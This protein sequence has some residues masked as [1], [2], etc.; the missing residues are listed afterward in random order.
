MDP[1]NG[2]RKQENVYGVYNTTCNILVLHKWASKTRRET[3]KLRNEKGIALATVLLFIIV[4]LLLGF[5]LTIMSTYDHQQAL[6]LE[7]QAKAYYIA[8]SGADALGSYI[9]N[10]PD[11]LTAQEMSDYVDAVV[12]AGV[13]DSTA[14]GEGSFSLAVTRD[15]DENTV[16]VTSTGIVQGISATA[17]Y[18]IAFDE[19]T[20][21]GPIL[22]M[23]V[24]STKERAGRYTLDKKGKLVLLP[25][26][27]SAI[28]LDGSAYIQGPVGTNSL[29]NS[30][31]AFDWSTKVYGDVNIGPGGNT[32]TAVTAP[33][34]MSNYVIS[35]GTRKVLPKIREY[36]LPA[37]PSFPALPSKSAYTAGWWPSPP[38]TLALTEGEGWYPSIKVLSTLRIEVGSGT[39]RLRIDTL[40]VTGSGKI[41][42]VG[43]GKLELYVT[44]L[45]IENSGRINDL[46]D[47]SR[48][49]MYYNGSTD[50][51]LGGDTRYYG[52]VYIKDA[53][54]T[55]GNSGG[56]Q[57]NIITGGSHVLINGDASAN[58]K[59]LY[60]PKADVTMGGSG[61][62][63]GALVAN[64]FFIDGGAWV[65]YVPIT[66]PIPDLPETGPSNPNF[67]KGRWK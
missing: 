53:T 48:V 16:E 6:R 11:N 66:Q 60:A 9:I 5:A 10:N 57:G 26:P 40:E 39:R 52:S 43:S 63:K 49:H 29:A 62:I 25:E 4:L 22:D 67:Q 3:M 31:V 45:K 21:G 51:N 32:N 38:Y 20:S 44:N 46:G 15:L 50:V 1:S 54:L 13:S 19:G 23:A 61:K 17:T 12:A 64:S 14:V 8:R 34:D 37:F 30:T 56:I 33:S 36:P 47:T 42:I 24:F 55:I 35:P 28:S 7:R 59:A 27:I 18:S 58:V 65:Q 2:G 41:E